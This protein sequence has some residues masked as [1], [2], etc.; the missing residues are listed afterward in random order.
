MTAAM[1]ALPFKRLML[2]GVALAHCPK[3]LPEE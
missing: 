1:W 3:G 2:D